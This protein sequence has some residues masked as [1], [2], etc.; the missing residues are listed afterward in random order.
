LKMEAPTRLTIR[1]IHHEEA[2]PH[3]P[4][5]QRCKHHAAC[6]PRPCHR[7][8]SYCHQQL[9]SKRLRRK[10]AAPTSCRCTMAL[11]RW[12]WWSPWPLPRSQ[13]YVHMP[14]QWWTIHSSGIRFFYRAPG[15]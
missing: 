5:Q 8:W 6:W 2:S 14:A 3:G 13:V 11:T 15:E 4:R 7:R 10:G 9:N 12:W 1:T